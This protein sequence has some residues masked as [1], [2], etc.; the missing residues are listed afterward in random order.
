MLNF[1]KS[2]GGQGRVLEKIKLGVSQ[3]FEVGDVVK[4]YSNGVADLGVA[5]TPILGVIVGFCKADGS[6]LQDTEVVAG[7]AASTDT[8][9]VTTDGTNSENIYAL[10]DVSPDS[11]YSA[12]VSGTLGTTNSSNLRGCWIDINSAGAEYGQVLET[13]AS[14]VAHSA[15]GA[16]CNFYSLGLDPEDSS[17][18]LVKIANSEEAT[19]I[20]V[21][22]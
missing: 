3:T 13:T 18:L 7:T 4:T 21:T 11:V 1:K 9:T 20:D 19:Q 8:V 22:P 17:R 15:T 14:R 6:P 12:E 5:A 10:V 2:R 16:M